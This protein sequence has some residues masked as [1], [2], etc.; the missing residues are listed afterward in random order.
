[1]QIKASSLRNGLE[2]DSFHGK[3]SINRFRYTLKY[4]AETKKY[5][6]VKVVFPSITQIKETTETVYSNANLSNT[7]RIYNDIATE[8]DSAIED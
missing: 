7:V 8:T 1:M 6:I 5:E 2:V 3:I 4:N